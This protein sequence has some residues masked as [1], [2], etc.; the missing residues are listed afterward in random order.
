MQKKTK[1]M[2]IGAVTTM[3]I[4]VIGVLLYTLPTTL[5]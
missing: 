5:P 1:N 2:L 4:A 3:V